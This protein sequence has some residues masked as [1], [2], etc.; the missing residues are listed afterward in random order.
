MQLSIEKQNSQI[1]VGATFLLFS[2]GFGEKAS[3]LH[4][5]TGCQQDC[6]CTTV[7][8]AAKTS[9]PTFT[10]ISAVNLPLAF[11]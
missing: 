10:P 1:S 11:W 3:G 2:N 7:H 5:L 4:S 8:L 6:C 9:T